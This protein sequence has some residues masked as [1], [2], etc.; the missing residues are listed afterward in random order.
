M[1]L[2]ET[3]NQSIF[4]NL[5]EEILGVI[6]SYFTPNERL[7]LLKY[8]YPWDKIRSKLMNM[9][10]KMKN[11]YK[12]LTCVNLVRPI[13][14]QFFERDGDIRKR[15]NFWLFTNPKEVKQYS[16]KQY[17]FD[18]VLIN[19]VDIIV[20]TI[21]HY[22]RMYKESQLAFVLSRYENVMIRLYAHLSHIQV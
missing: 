16:F 20:S 7:N 19:F 21:R 4:A 17:S 8:K 10:K 2:V 13:I 3:Q 12:L 14:I 11:L 18:L 1:S 5:P 22:G 6:F 15:I 9:P